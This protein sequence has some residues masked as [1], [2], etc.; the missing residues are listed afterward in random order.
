MTV[1]KDRRNWTPGNVHAELESSQKFKVPMMTKERANVG[2]P[3]M[4]PERSST[5]C[6]VN[7]AKETFPPLMIYNA[8]IGLGNLESISGCEDASCC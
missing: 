7:A 5:P 6:D 3:P 8:K 2:R 4:A 1:A